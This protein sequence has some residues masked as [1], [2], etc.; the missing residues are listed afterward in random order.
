M[1]FVTELIR[2]YRPFL[3]NEYILGCDCKT[4][5]EGLTFWAAP[6]SIMGCTRDNYLYSD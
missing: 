1:N 5:D 6:K 4:S 2:S 3:Q